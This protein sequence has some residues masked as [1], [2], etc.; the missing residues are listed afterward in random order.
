MSTPT[1]ALAVALAI[2]LGTGAPDAA[3]VVPSAAEL[4]AK[5]VASQ[6][7]SGFTMRARLIMQSAD[8]A[9]AP[10]IVQIRA[11]GRRDPTGTRVL[12]QAL[13]PDAVKGRAV[14]V[15][16]ASRQ[17]TGGFFFV[18]PDETTP[19]TAA[20][21]TDAILDSD[22]TVEDLAEDFQQWPD[23]VYAGQDKV[24]GGSCRIV[25]SRPPAGTPSSY[26]LV[27]SCV[28]ESKL[29]LLRIEKMGAGGR[30]IKRF[31]V[32][33][34]A[35]AESGAVSPRTIEIQNL[36][37]GSSTT[38]DVSRGE[39]DIAVSAKEFTPARLRTLGK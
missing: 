36:A 6:R 15:E 28:S 10:V 4:M 9:K 27:R 25:E 33:K 22:L 19:I 29:L 24:R 11:L 2:A 34:T 3:V 12:Y 17:P 23:P 7:T 18:P 8:A 16:R 14:V 37:R 30:V 1:A 31:T 20:R 35:L 5:V 26:P 39:R 13:W 38:I 32:T 21:L